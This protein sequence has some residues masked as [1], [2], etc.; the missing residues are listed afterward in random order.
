MKHLS[1]QQIEKIYNDA[2]RDMSLTTHLLEKSEFEMYL[3]GLYVKLSKLKSSE[4]EKQLQMVEWMQRWLNKQ[5]Y[6]NTINIVQAGLINEL[7][8][9]VVKLEYDKQELI[10]ENVKLKE[11][12]K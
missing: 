9:Q 6:I 10:N 7:N 5:R 2:V 8:N 11:N 1:N 12:I 4:A 3:T